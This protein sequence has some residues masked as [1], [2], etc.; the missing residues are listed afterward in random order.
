[1]TNAYDTLH[2]YIQQ[3]LNTAGK[4]PDSNLLDTFESFAQLKE[5]PANPDDVRSTKGK[6]NSDGTAGE[7]TNTSPF[8]VFRLNFLEIASLVGG[9][10]KDAG[11]LLL[12]TGDFDLV[13]AG[14]ALTG[15]LNRFLKA[16]TKKLQPADAKVI[17]AIA[18]VD[19]KQCRK[20]DVQLAYR[21][22]FLEDLPEEHLE[23]SITVLEKLHILIETGAS[24]RLKDQL[25]ISL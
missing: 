23:N 7:V 12:D 16:T 17:F 20:T 8:N 24:I 2:A 15:L 21:E 1:M 5:G 14:I 13:K 6:L 9:T 10:I 3:D 19:K 22:L 25:E 11:I 4:T 18:R